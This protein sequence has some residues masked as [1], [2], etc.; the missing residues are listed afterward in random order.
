MRAIRAVAVH[1][2]SEMN[3][4]GFGGECMALKLRHGALRERV[5]SQIEMYTHFV[6]VAG[7]NLKSRY[8][9][10][11]GQLEH[12]VY[13]LKT[14]VNRWKRRYPETPSRRLSNVSA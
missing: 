6:E 13:E 3:G 14:G 9:M 8:M 12:R 2:R 4:E 10:L 11:V 1:E 7:P 5:A